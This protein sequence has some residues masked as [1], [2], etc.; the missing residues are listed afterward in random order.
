M[1][2]VRKFDKDSIIK[3]SLELIEKEGKSNFNAR[4]L[5]SYLGSSVQPIFHNFS[6]MEELYKYVYQA[7]YNFYSS[8][9]FE[10]SKEEENSYKKIGLTYIRFAKEHKEFFKIIFMGKT[11]F[12]SDNFMANGKE[13]DDIIKAGCKLTGLGYEEQKDFHKRVWIFTHGI[14]CLVNTETVSMSDMEIENLLTSTVR[15]MLIGYR[16]G[17]MY[18]KNN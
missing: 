14:A 4:N 3:A 11:D 5:A 10:A 13:V 2:P 8:L 12:N 7:I 6:N 17:K 18:E 16:K 15:S 9:M 1:P